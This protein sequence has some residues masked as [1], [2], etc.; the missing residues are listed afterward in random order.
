MTDNCFLCLEKAKKNMCP[1]GVCKMKCHTKCYRKYM[2]VNG[3]KNITCPVCKSVK[4]NKYNLRKRNIYKRVDKN[5]FIK[6]I[7]NFLFL[8][9]QYN[10]TDNKKE[11]VIEMF[12]FIYYNLWF[13]RKYER[14]ANVF[15]DKLIELYIQDNWNYANE[16]HKRLYGSFIR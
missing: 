7:K 6:R 9:E 15:K 4:L 8:V 11:I 12:E 2:E 13:L 10:G 5:E 3:K 14:F 1:A 16:V